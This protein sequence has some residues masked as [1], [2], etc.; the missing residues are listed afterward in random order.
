MYGIQDRQGYDLNTYRSSVIHLGSIKYRR[1]RKISRGVLDRT[2]STMFSINNHKEI[3]SMSEGL[4]ACTQCGEQFAAWRTSEPDGRVIKVSDICPKCIAANK[5]RTAYPGAPEVGGFITMNQI[6]YK[7][8]A[9]DKL[10]G[11]FTAKRVPNV[12]VN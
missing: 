1:N 10:K 3:I 2:L 12:K 11:I 4:E 8:I 9:S 5:K 7:V 6:H